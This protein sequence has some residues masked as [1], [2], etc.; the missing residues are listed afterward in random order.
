[1]SWAHLRDTAEIV[2]REED[3]SQVDS[4]LEHA[5]VDEADREKVQL[6]ARGFLRVSGEEAV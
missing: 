6:E 3:L 1:M 5:G 4:G 2:G